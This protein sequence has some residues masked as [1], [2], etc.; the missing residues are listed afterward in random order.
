MNTGLNGEQSAAVRADGRGGGGGVDPHSRHGKHDTDQTQGIPTAVPP[1]VPHG[2]PSHDHSS[3]AEVSSVIKRPR[4]PTSQHMHEVGL[5]GQRA[6][7]G[8][9]P[10]AHMCGVPRVL[11]RTCVGVGVAT[12]ACGA[13]RTDPVR[14]FMVAS[15]RDECLRL[16]RPERRSRVVYGRCTGPGRGA[17]QTS[18]DSCV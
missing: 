17:S 3:P 4:C 6:R 14:S 11:P 13:C 16:P 12:V 15:G 1:T 2:R 8:G 9:I 10:A 5:Q 7:L 18:S